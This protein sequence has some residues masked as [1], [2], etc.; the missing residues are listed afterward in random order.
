MTYMLHLCFTGSKSC[1][2]VYVGTGITDAVSGSGLRS[3]LPSLSVDLQFHRNP[4][5]FNPSQWL[6]LHHPHSSPSANISLSPTDPNLNPV[7]QTRCLHHRRQMIHN[8]EP[9]CPLTHVLY[10]VLT[11]LVCARPQPCTRTRRPLHGKENRIISRN[12]HQEATPPSLY[13]DNHAASCVLPTQVKC[14]L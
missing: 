4:P 8:M 7:L 3:S 6:S 14:V 2:V 12:T 5:Q 1:M 10:L 9:R 13:W 11:E